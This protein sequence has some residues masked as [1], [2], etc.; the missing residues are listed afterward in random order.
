MTNEFILVSAIVAHNKVATEPLS[1]DQIQTL[2]NASGLNYSLI[3]DILNEMEVECTPT[4]MFGNR[5]SA[6]IA[7]AKAENPQDEDLLR[8][9]EFYGL[10]V[11]YANKILDK[12]AEKS[13]KLVL[14]Y[15]E[16]INKLVNL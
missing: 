12:Y 2:A 3:I 16:Q 15:E 7:L 14:D 4:T 13:D 10:Y 1:R 5:L 6:A 8:L 11:Q 9:T